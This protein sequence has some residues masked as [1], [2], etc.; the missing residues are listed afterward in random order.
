MLW[1][2]SHIGQLLAYATSSE[3]PPVTVDVITGDTDSM[4]PFLAALAQQRHWG[5]AHQETLF[6]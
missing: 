5:R 6:A 2:A 3:P 4:Q 1:Q